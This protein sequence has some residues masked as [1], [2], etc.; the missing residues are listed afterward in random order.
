MMGRYDQLSHF[1]I[2]NVGGK[3]NI[4][5]VTHCMTRLRFTL[6]DYSLVNATKLK[7]NN[8]IATAQKAGG[9]YQVVIGTHVGDVYNEILDK[10]GSGKTMEADE[11]KGVLNSIIQIITKVIT[12]ILGVLLAS[13]L[14]QGLLMILT[15]TGLV[16]ETD[17]AHI[18]LNAMGQA[19]FSFFPVILGYTSA[20]AFKLD[21]A[22]GI[23]IGAIT[24]FPGLTESLAGGEVMMTLFEGSFIATPVYQTFFGI[25]IMFP[26]MGY[27]STVIPI[28][29]IVFFASK[30]NQLLKKKIPSVMAFTLVPFLTILITL[31]ISLLIIG[32]ITNLLSELISNSVST[33]YGISSIFTSFIVALVYQ[34]LVI[35]GLHWPLITLG[36]QNFGIHGFDYIL[37]T[38]FTASFAQTAVVAAVYFKTKSRAQKEI[39]IPALISALFCIIEPAIYG[40]T[41]PVKKRFAFSMIGGAI[42][43][44]F[45]S[46]LGANMYAGVVGIFGFVSFLNPDGSYSGLIISIIGV[47]ISMIISFLLTYFT[48]DEKIESGPKETVRR[49]NPGLGEVVIASPLKGK[50]TKL[51]NATDSAFANGL[52]G[53]GI[54]F[55]PEGNQ[56]VAPFDGEITTIFPTGHAVGMTSTDGLELL[57]HVGKDTVRLE[58]EY[59][60][61]LKAQGD[62]VKKGEPIIEFDLKALKEANVTIETPVVMTNSDQYTD[63]LMTDADFIDYSG[64]LMS[65]QLKSERENVSIGDLTEERGSLV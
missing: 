39:A 12:P 47:A 19:I 3:D 6:N 57:I 17:G 61:K 7:E 27:G 50:V 51:E 14:I 5:G 18:I 53:K 31:P 54:L 42:G 38:L 36:L 29:F 15:F 55:Y 43:G 44:T 48:F 20:K 9:Q 16:Q 2:E 65:V 21:P 26:V 49:D 41:L 52:L 13:G 64:E 60:K 34:P 63:I 23:I 33:L 37:P 35:L 4:I 10:I 59:F 58:G 22:I 56:V 28:I 32:P 45:I 1:I 11:K 46:V 24:I 62:F 8:E 40:V 25:P 30:I